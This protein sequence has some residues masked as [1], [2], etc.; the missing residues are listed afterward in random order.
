MENNITPPLQPSKYPATEVRHFDTFAEAFEAQKRRILLLGKPDAGKTTTLYQFTL[1]AAEVCLHS[2]DITPPTEAPIPLFLYVHQWDCTTP[3][4]EWAHAQLLSQF[5]GTQVSRRD[6]Q[7]FLYIFDGLDELGTERPV[8]PNR[9]DAGTYDPRQKFLQAVTE[10]LPDASVVIS[11]RER[12]Y[13]ELEEKATLKGA[14]T[15]LPL[16]PQQIKTFLTA[17]NQMPLW[18]ALVSDSSL[19]ELART[20]LLLALLSVAVGSGPVALP[21]EGAAV[22]S[23]AIFDFYIHQR[24]AHEEVKRP[25]TF[26]E[27]TTRINLGELGARMWANRNAPLLDLDAIAVKQVLGE[28]ADAF[29]SFACS[30]HFL[31]SSAT[32]GVR[33]IHL[34]FRDYCAI[35]ALSEQLTS[36]DSHSSW[37]AAETLGDI[38]TAAIP[39]LTKCLRHPLADVRSYAALALAKIGEEAAIPALVQTLTDEDE[40]VHR[41]AAEALG[42]IGL[43][44]LP[45]LL[46]A[47][48]HEDA[49]VRWIVAYSLGT[50]GDV[51]AIPALAQ[52]LKDR[53]KDVRAMAAEALSTIGDSAAVPLL[54]TALNDPDGFVRGSV[55]E[56]LGILGDARAIPAL[57]QTLGDMDSFA[58][59]RA[60]EALEILKQSTSSERVYSGS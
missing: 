22:T 45:A 13:N 29:I 27:V 9:P 59:R 5:F 1:E 52:T 17:R 38:G 7:D 30:L 41:R 8:D 54:I 11:C 58:R 36:A 50:V 32:G 31:Q 34:A 44:A 57:R 53:E 35:P 28:D 55:A 42:T 40:L 21:M 47:L 25:L 56:A 24:L 14:V 15:L 43:P 4:A 12:D 49:H 37:A 60:A 3:L 23:N 20:P 51:R 39:A 46:D 48:R 18:E 10:Q 33:F 19:M 2:L 16:R 6:P 26:D